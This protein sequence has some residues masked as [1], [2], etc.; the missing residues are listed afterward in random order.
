MANI[1]KAVGFI[2]VQYRH[3]PLLFILYLKYAF[4]VRNA[5]Y[6]GWPH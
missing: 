2:K 3:N 4:L 1:D 5:P 6:F